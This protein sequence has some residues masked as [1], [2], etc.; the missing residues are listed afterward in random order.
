MCSNSSTYQDHCILPFLRVVGEGGICPLY[1]DVSGV[2]KGKYSPVR[3]EDR[4]NDSASCPR[5]LQQWV[6]TVEAHILYERLNS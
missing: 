4:A 2:F 3:A 5:K 6:L 1:G